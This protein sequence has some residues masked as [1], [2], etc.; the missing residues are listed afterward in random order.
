M[1][2]VI[3]Y[4]FP[5]DIGLFSNLNNIYDAETF[6]KALREVLFKLQ[7]KAATVKKEEKETELRVPRESRIENILRNLQEHNIQAMKDVL[8]I[9]ASLQALY[10]SLIHI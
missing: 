8:L 5:G 10:L 1:G 9:F 2:K 6:S 4:N 7:K 3:G